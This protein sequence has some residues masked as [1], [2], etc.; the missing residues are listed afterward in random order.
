[1]TQTIRPD[2]GFIPTPY[3]AMN[4]MLDLAQ[5][6]DQDI[7]YDLGC[8]DGRFLI[9]AAQQYHCRG[10]GIDID[11]QQL[12]KA[13]QAAKKGGVESFLTFRQENLFN[14]NIT[15]ATVVILY[16]LPH[17][18]LR[19]RPHLFQQLRPQTRIISHQFDMDNWLPN[20]TL[21]LPDSE[22][23]STLYLWVIPEK[24]EIVLSQKIRDS[25]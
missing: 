25:Q 23:E 2:I 20:K 8:G 15:E 21:H 1:M 11:P 17:L 16:L 3:D 13:R 7:V 4:T 5:L 14:A 6:T 10:V 12:Q 19:L 24:T 9:Q 22:E 18:N